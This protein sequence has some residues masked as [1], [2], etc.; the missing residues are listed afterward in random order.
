M[1]NQKS[2]RPLLPPEE[3]IQRINKQFPNIWAAVKKN[4]E[5]IHS[6]K[7]NGAPAFPAMPS[8]MEM[9]TGLVHYTVSHT[10]AYEAVMTAARFQGMNK[11]IEKMEDLTILA[12]VYAWKKSKNVYRFAPELYNELIHQEL[13]TSVNM[14]VFF[15]L[16][17]YGT[18]VETPGLRRDNKAVKGVLAYI[19]Q[20]PTA[21]DEYLYC[22]NLCYFMNDKDT[23]HTVDIFMYNMDGHTTLEMSFN[24]VFDALD[25]Y[26]EK[27]ESTTITKDLY[28]EVMNRDRFKKQ[29]KESSP[30]LNLL[31][32]LCSKEPDISEA[33]KPETHHHGKHNKHTDEPKEWDVGIRISRMLLRSKS[34]EQGNPEGNGLGSAKRPHIRSAHWHSYWIGPR[35][36]TYPNR[37]IIIKWL[38]PIPINV[39]DEEALPVVIREVP[40]KIEN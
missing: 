1:N 37:R 14:D 11:F 7:E 13:D 4:R 26:N 16:P 5:N 6:L 20:Q 23:P 33:S 2:E 19:E 22:L 30:F 32:F 12:P 27:I 10:P 29:I 3:Y 9:T 24:N 39:R 38:P 34:N 40:E 8:W 15:Q 31:M 21:N 18:Y 28:K 35:D 36:E 25:E 17:Q